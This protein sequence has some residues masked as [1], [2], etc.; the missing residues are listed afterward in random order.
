MRGLVTLIL[1]IKVILTTS[2]YKKVV[3]QR[4]VSY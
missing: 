2:N 3:Y 4:H 1:H